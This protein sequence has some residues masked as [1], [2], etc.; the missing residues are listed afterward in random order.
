MLHTLGKYFEIVSQCCLNYSTTTPFKETNHEIHL[1]CTEFWSCYTH[2][3]AQSLQVGMYL[4]NMERGHLVHPTTF[5][6]NQNLLR[7]HHHSRGGHQ[8]YLHHQ[9]GKAEG[10]EPCSHQWCPIQGSDRGSFIYAV[11]RPK[12]LPTFCFQIIRAM[13]KH[14]GISKHRMISQSFKD[15]SSASKSSWNF[16]SWRGIRNVQWRIDVSKG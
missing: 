3:I 4:P 13:S 14:R 9:S 6:K 2:G 5:G 12:I 11:S 15:G 10:C 8:P 7:H 1:S 16:R